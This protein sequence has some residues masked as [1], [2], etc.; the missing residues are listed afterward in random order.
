ML[1]KHEEVAQI[2]KIRKI[3]IWY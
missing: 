3:W 2:F 1:E